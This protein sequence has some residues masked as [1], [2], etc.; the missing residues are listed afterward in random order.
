METIS[1]PDTSWFPHQ[2]IPVGMGIDDGL[3]LRLPDQRRHCGEHAASQPRIPQRVD[4]QRLAIA[5]HEGS[6]TLT[7]H[8]VRLQPGVDT[9]ADLCEASLEL[10][11][12]WMKGGNREHLYDQP[13]A[14]CQ[15]VECASGLRDDLDHRS[16]TIDPNLMSPRRFQLRSADT[17]LVGYEQVGGGFGTNSWHCR[18]GGQT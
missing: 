9:G 14:Q 1:A 8:A 6:I 3:D 13:N 18:S 17:R 16:T 2:W 4:Q 10:R 11:R 12:P 7:E 5:Q 15:F